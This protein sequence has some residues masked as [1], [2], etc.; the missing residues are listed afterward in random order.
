MPRLLVSL[1]GVESFELAESFIHVA[2]AQYNAVI[3]S[4]CILNKV[5]VCRAF[6]CIHMYLGALGRPLLQHYGEAVN[7]LSDV[8]R[9]VLLVCYIRPWLRH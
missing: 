2:C 3:R 4:R 1:P 6:T 7:V 5:L 9:R 8:S